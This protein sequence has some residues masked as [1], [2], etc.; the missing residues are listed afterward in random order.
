M[1]KV[2]EE[3]N[4]RRRGGKTAWRERSSLVR[5]AVRDGC[6]RWVQGG[7][8]KRRVCFR[9]KDYIG[10]IVVYQRNSNSSGD[11]SQLYIRPHI[12]IFSLSYAVRVSPT[13]ASS[14]P[15]LAVN[16][17]ERSR[18]PT[19][20]QMSDQSRSPSS[21]S[22]TRCRSLTRSR[23]LASGSGALPILSPGSG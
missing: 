7:Q 22:A 5:V 9:Q 15:Y 10:N 8:I 6:V 1:N 18:R 2:F 19:F 23:S 21:S 16:V 13:A 14:I 11:T 17:A 3:E 20:G 12:S 4:C